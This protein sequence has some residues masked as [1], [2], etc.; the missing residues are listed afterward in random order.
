[1]QKF[2]KN[3]LCPNRWLSNSGKFMLSSATIDNL[4]KKGKL[5]WDK[6]GEKAP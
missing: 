5:V 6:L 1:M 2:M 4:A 3:L